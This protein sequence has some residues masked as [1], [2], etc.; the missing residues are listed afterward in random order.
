MLYP[1]PIRLVPILTPNPLLSPPEIEKQREG[2]ESNAGEL[3]GIL[4]AFFSNSATGTSMGANAIVSVW[5]RE[6]EEKR[7]KERERRR[8]GARRSR[9]CVSVLQERDAKTMKSL[10]FE[11]I[12]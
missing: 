5:E 8:A 4:G 11:Y 9:I 1:A 7:G 2:V 12:F 6:G 10:V 3:T